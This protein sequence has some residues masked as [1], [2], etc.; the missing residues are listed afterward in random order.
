MP[1]VL[2]KPLKPFFTYFGGKW[3]VTKHYPIPN[4]NTVIEPFCG[5]AGYSL[6]YHNRRIHLYDVDPIV[7]SVWNYLIRVK[8]SEILQLPL[9]ITD[10][11][12]MKL[13]QEAKWLIGFWLNKGT[14]SP[15]NMPSSWAASGKGCYWGETVR[16]RIA[17]QIGY[18]RHWRIF[19]GS[20]EDIENQDATWFVDPP[21][22]M[23]G[24]HYRHNKIDYFKLADWCRQ[25]LGQVIV[26][27]QHGAKWLP[28]QELRTIR[29]LD[30]A[31]GSKVSKEVIWRNS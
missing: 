23:S 14:S 8:I 24:V 17:Y 7:C 30:G 11:R 26:C 31:K 5:S 28:F 2:P 29:T 15:R 4:H 12:R 25:R 10:L 6:H 3:R 20:Y 21:Y 9:V 27:E 19:K 22:Q 16:Q 1:V 13:P 18:I